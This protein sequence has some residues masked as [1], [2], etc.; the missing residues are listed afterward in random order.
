MDSEHPYRR[1]NGPRPLLPH[2][3]DSI[4]LI[5]V[6]NLNVAA[7]KA[8]LFLEDDDVE[9]KATK[10]R[11]LRHV[12]FGAPLLRFEAV[13]DGIRQAVGVLFHRL[14]AVRLRVLI[15]SL[16]QEPSG[17]SILGKVWL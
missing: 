9:R 2:E 14:L 4:T 17:G 15:P 10:L 13:C 5:R 8:A 16:L 11:I 1:N 7:T 12:A 6:P 3:R